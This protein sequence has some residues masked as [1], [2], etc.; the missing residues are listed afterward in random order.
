LVLKTA[1]NVIILLVGRS[2]LRKI[3]RQFHHGH[4]AANVRFKRADSGLRAR[5]LCLLSHLKNLQ[6][7]KAYSED[8]GGPTVAVAVIVGI[9]P[10]CFPPFL[11]SPNACCLPPHSPLGIATVCVISVFFP[12]ESS[13]S[14]NYIMGSGHIHLHLEPSSE[15]SPQ[16]TSVIQTLVSLYLHLVTLIPSS[17]TRSILL[18]LFE[19]PGV[20]DL[21]R[22]SCDLHP[23]GVETARLG[24]E[25]PVPGGDGG[26][27]WTPG[28]TR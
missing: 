24:P 13:L 12:Q 23:G 9:I 18:L 8:Q 16:E 17:S 25:D 26:D 2:R 11:T 20:G 19:F 5:G 4:T 22:C 7:V 21:Q 14:H 15:L 1:G 6:L 10:S 3:I 28:L 27:L